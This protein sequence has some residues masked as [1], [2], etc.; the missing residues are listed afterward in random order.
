MSDKLKG[1]GGGTT[2]LDDIRNRNRQRI[3]AFIKK[4][5]GERGV[6]WQDEIVKALGL[7][8]ATVMKHLAQL[9]KKGHIIIEDTG[10]TKLIHTRKE[11]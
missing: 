9:E 6:T 10:V 11:K 5:T 1:S 8:K 7:Q 3:L 4:K 2:K